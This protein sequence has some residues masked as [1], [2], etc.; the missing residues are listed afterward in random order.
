MNINEQIQELRDS[1]NLYCDEH[2]I[3]EERVMEIADMIKKRN[4]L[5]YQTYNEVWYKRKPEDIYFTKQDLKEYALPGLAKVAIHYRPN[6]DQALFEEIK[7]VFNVDVCD[8]YDYSYNEENL[9]KEYEEMC[10]KYSPQDIKFIVWCLKREFPDKHVEYH[11]YCGCNQGD[12]YDCFFV[13]DKDVD[14]NEEV[15]IVRDYCKDQFWQYDKEP[16]EYDGCFHIAT[17]MQSFLPS[18]NL[19]NEEE[20]KEHLKQFSGTDREIIIK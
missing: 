4:S 1:I 20:I 18:N 12:Y 15:A 2:A 10:E 11:C 14:I 5:I 9:D 7:N 8:I 6:K 16:D 13:S 17:I 3:S 19:D